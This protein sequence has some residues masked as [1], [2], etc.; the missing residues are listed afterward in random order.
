M[1]SSS[2]WLFFAVWL[3][4]PG[5][6]AV[7]LLVLARRTRRAGM[8]WLFVA[9]GIWPILSIVTNRALIWFG[10]Q[11]YGPSMMWVYYVSWTGMQVVGVFLEIVAAVKLARIP[12][13]LP[14]EPLCPTCGYNL[15][16]LAE[17]RCPECGMGFVAEIRYLTRAVT[18][19]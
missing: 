4:A 2:E 12:G 13:P 16:G 7:V 6:V 5:L 10:L 18:G 17:D 3:A 15:T 1:S 19:R 11:V 8:W 9:L 14:S